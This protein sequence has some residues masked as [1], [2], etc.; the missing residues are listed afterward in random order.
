MTLSC[1]ALLP[2]ILLPKV[3]TDIVVL[4]LH[5]EGLEIH[6]VFNENLFSP[7]SHLLKKCVMVV[8]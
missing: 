1:P 2:V 8:R 3:F 6:I 7:N 4:N 5:V